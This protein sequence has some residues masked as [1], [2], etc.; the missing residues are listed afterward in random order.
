M[1]EA[2]AERDEGRKS[3]GGEATICIGT[4]S[5]VDKDHG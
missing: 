3:F 2:K 1:G 4:S 5:G